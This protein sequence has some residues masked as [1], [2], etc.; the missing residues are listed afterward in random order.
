MT[1]RSS[2]SAKLGKGS[3]GWDAASVSRRSEAPASF[4]ADRRHPDLHAFERKQVRGLGEHEQQHGV[5]LGDQLGPDPRRGRHGEVDRR[6]PEQ[7]GGVA[8]RERVRAVGREQG[9]QA[10]ACDVEI[11]EG[12][13][14]AEDRGQEFRCRRVP[15]LVPQDGGIARLAQPGN[16]QVDVQ[17]A[18]AGQGF[19]GLLLQDGH[20]PFLPCSSAA[21][22]AGSGR[23]PTGPTDRCRP[24]R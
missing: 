6:R 18:R 14:V 21:A 17:S 12:A 8:D 22:D 15:A 13:G 4:R 16:Q 19:A 2:G 11:G 23:P 9:D 7:V 1:A 24:S 5:D 3:P 20:S 10:A